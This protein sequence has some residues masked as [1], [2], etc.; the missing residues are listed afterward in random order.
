MGVPMPFN[1]ILV[2]EFYANTWRIDEPNQT[3]KSYCRG[4]DITYDSYTIN[5][6][7]GVLENFKPSDE[8]TI[9]KNGPYPEAEIER[10]LLKDG[11]HW[12]PDAET[13]HILHILQDQLK[14]NPRVWSEF[15][16]CNVLPRSNSNEIPKEHAL[17]HYAICMGYW[18]STGYQYGMMMMIRNQA[19][20]Q[21]IQGCTKQGRVAHAGARRSIHLIPD[22]K[23]LLTSFIDTADGFLR[24]ANRNVRKE[25]SSFLLRSRHISSIA[26]RQEQLVVNL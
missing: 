18:N 15:M 17:L 25:G 2:K 7:L 12:V 10:E 6:L 9:M 26:I 20:L 19:Q 23:L 22:Q 16:L 11:C 8:Y 24:S 5:E 3:F 13:G 1:E 14:P 4:K 21:Y